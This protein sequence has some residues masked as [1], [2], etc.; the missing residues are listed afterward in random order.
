MEMQR[1]QEEIPHSTQHDASLELFVSEDLPRDGVS[2]QLVLVDEHV[3][4]DGVHM[5]DA[6]R[7]A[8]GELVSEV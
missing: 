2:A 1:T 5:D 7:P 4:R 8:G 3:F 6:L